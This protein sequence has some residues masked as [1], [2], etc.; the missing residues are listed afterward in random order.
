MTHLLPLTPEGAATSAIESMASFMARL[1]ALHGVNTYQLV[2]HLRD[3]TGI[4]A[5]GTQAVGRCAGRNSLLLAGFGA[6]ARGA[7]EWLRAGLGDR[8]WSA[9]TLLVFQDVL[10]RH[11]TG[12]LRAERAW[13][14][15]CFWEM[16]REERPE[17]EKLLWQVRSLSR[18]HIHQ[19]KLQTACPACGAVQP[20]YLVTSGRIS[21]CRKCGSD[22]AGSKSARLP[23]AR[24]VA[25]EKDLIGIIEAQ[26]ADAH[27]K[28]VPS[29][30]SI[31]LREYLRRTDRPRD[32]RS[33]LHRSGVDIGNFRSAKY[34]ATLATS[35]N[36]S[37]ITEV[38]LRQLLEAPFEAA[39][40]VRLDATFA[41][42]VT[43]S[44]R[45]LRPKQL[46]LDFERALD[47]EIARPPGQL[48]TSLKSLSR[49]FGL[50]SATAEY[51]YPAKASRLVQR[52]RAEVAVLREQK[53]KLARDALTQKGLPAYLAGEMRSQDEVVDWAHKQYGLSK[54][55]LRRE[56][57][58]VI[59]PATLLRRRTPSP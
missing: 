41:L 38:P 13:C 55:L 52:Y 47:A 25:C 35:I 53:T 58:S 48:P 18:C 56:L 12:A 9:L 24:P 49:R 30:V 27:Y 19:I 11:G 46:R 34:R 17:Y 44:P 3:W 45:V 8:H 39:K 36:L 42:R 54:S 59:S 26:A 16:R 43:P 20:D 50:T 14:P 5:F 32:M 31:F 33:M 22:I 21:L 37:L 51:W 4:H 40:I 28:L 1:S 7:V 10:P 23:S 2:N 15:A 29:P 57:L 6:G